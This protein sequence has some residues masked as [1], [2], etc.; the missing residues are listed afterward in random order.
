MVQHEELWQPRKAEAL[1]LRGPIG[2]LILIA[3]N[4][5]HCRD[6]PLLPSN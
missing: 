5:S 6:F 3:P 4:F 1:A 2:H